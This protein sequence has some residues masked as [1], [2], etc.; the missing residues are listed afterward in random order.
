MFVRAQTRHNFDTGNDRRVKFFRKRIGIKQNPVHAD[1]HFD[2]VGV[3]VYVNIRRAR[4]LG[5]FYELINEVYDGR[6]GAAGDFTLYRCFWDHYYEK[7]KKSRLIK[8]I[9]PPGQKELFGQTR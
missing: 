4:G 2:A 9:S 1:A 3:R 7:P 5:V 6:L 8:N